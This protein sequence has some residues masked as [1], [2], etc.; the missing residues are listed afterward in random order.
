MS[1]VGAWV[2]PVVEDWCHTV[3]VDL[4][5]SDV[6]SH[7][8]ERWPVDSLTVQSVVDVFLMNRRAS[9]GRYDVLTF[10]PVT[11]VR[12]KPVTLISVEDASV[13][14]PVEARETL[15]LRSRLMRR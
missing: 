15:Q 3:K 7:H 12:L 11:Y 4:G 8:V 13:A 6:A 2:L 1:T 9:V 10:Q 14:M 5:A